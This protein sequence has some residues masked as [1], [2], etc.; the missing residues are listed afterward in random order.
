MKKL[1]SLAA[2]IALPFAAMAGESGKEVT[3]EGTGMCAKCTLNEADSCTNALQTTD[4]DG[5]VTTYIFTENIKHREH[6]CQGKTEDLVVKG[7]VTEKDGKLLLDPV[8][9]ETKEKS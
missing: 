7:T 9:V 6:F 3:L 4:A 1:L 2:L 5:K 8:S